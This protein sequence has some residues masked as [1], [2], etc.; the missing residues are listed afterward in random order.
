MSIPERSPRKKKAKK[1][2]RESSATPFPG[3]ACFEESDLL[4]DERRKKREDVETVAKPKPTRTRSLYLRRTIGGTPSTKSD[5]PT[6]DK[7]IFPGI[8]LFSEEQ[9][10]VN[11]REKIRDQFKIE[12][13][14][15]DWAGGNLEA[16][17]KEK[18]RSFFGKLTSSRV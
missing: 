6:S 10:N 3:I 17:K 12:K 14:V 9:I 16:S 5:P 11:E 13:A 18:R 1:E 8:I 2:R 15:E 4:I 7:E